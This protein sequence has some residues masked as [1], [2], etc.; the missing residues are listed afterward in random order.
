[1]TLG[2]EGVDV[3]QAVIAG[4][5]EVFRDA[6]I[7]NAAVRSTPDG[8]DENQA[9]EGAPLVGQVVVDELFA[10]ALEAVI[11]LFEASKADRR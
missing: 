8:G 1:L 6:L 7:Q 5:D 3:L 11:A 10:G 2:D 4:A 9:G